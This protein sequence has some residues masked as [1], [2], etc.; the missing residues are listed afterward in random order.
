M[1][2]QWLTT[3]P[4]RTAVI[5]TAGVGS[6]LRPLTDLRPKPL[7]EVNGTPIPHNALR[8]LQAVGVEEV[9]IIVGYR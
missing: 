9:T 1:D 6:R 4:P 3:L 5:L 8:N 2:I 7:V